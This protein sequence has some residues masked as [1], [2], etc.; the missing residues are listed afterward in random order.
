MLFRSDLAVGQWSHAAV[1]YDGVTLRLYL[2]AV[3]VGSTPLSGAVD[4]APSVPVTVGSQPPGAGPRF[5]DGLID[6]VRILSRALSQ[7]ELASIL[8]L[9]NRAPVALNDSY[10]TPEGIPLSVTAATGVLNNDTDP[11]FDPLQTVL[12]DNVSNGVLTL[13]PDGS[14]DYVPNVGFGGQDGF[15]YLANDTALDSNLASVTISVSP[16]SMGNDQPR[17]AT[18]SVAFVK[19]VVDDTLGDTHAV[20]AADFTG[21][22]HVDLVATD[23][24]DGMV[25]WYENDGAGGFITRVLDPALGGAYPVGVGDVDGDGDIDICSKLWRADPQNANGGKNHFDY[26]EN[27]TR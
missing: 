11:D 19:R 27:R 5:F 22:G 23:F 4:I 17:I 16:V 14:F 21:D 26:L 20:A 24:L 12:V 7:S 3:E 15:T 13:N 18:G 1:T 9:P 6:D 2:D 25:F 10:Q 8:N